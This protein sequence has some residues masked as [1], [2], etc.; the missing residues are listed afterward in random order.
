MGVQQLPE[1]SSSQAEEP[2]SKRVCSTVKTAE[3]WGQATCQK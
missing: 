3:K 2:S 1:H